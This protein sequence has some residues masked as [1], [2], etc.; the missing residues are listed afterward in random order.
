MPGLAKIV[1]NGALC[2]VHIQILVE[3][4]LCRAGN[5]FKKGRGKIKEK[6]NDT[7]E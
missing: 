2:T 7:T 4:F 3:K 1:V 6:Y 5:R